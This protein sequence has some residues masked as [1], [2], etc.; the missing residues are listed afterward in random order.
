MAMCLGWKAPRDCNRMEQVVSP[1]S[2]CPSI[3]WFWLAAAG[4]VVASMLTPN[5][6]GKTAAA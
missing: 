3:T 5:K 2:A 4:V 1:G 6:K